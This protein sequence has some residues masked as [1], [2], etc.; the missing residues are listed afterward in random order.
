MSVRE[1]LELDISEAL[2]A[3]EDVGSRLEN[4]AQ[5][6]GDLLGEAL[7]GAL[8]GLPVITPEVD[9]TTVSE[10]V[11]GALN[12]ATDAP[13]EIDGEA[14]GVTDAVDSALADAETT[15]T[16]DADADAVTDEGQAAIDSID[17]TVTVNAD[18][19]QAEQAI[20]GLSD[21]LG[22]LGG[23]SEDAAGGLSGVT[24]AAVLAGRGAAGASGAVGRVTGAL[25]SLGPAGIAAGAAI[26]GVAAGAGFLYN[27]AFEAVAVTQAWENSL[28]DLGEQIMDLDGGATG[29]SGTIAQLAQDTGSSDE[30]VLIA[31]Q[32]YA[33]FQRAAGF[34]NDQIVEN[35]QGIVAL[36]AQIRVNNPNLGT[37]DQIITSLSRSLQRGGPRLQQF[38][39]ALNTADIEA[40][41][42]SMTGKTVATELTNAEKSAAGLAIAMEQIQPSAEGLAAGM[43]N[44]AIQSARAQQKIGDTL[45]ELGKPIVAPATQA[46]LA[47]AQAFEA[48]ASV[49]APLYQAIGKDLADA[50]DTASVSLD[51]W[52]WALNQLGSLIGDASDDVDDASSAMDIFGGV[53]EGVS[54][55]TINQLGPLGSLFNLLNDVRGATDDSGEAIATATGVYYG[56]TGAV[57]EAGQAVPQLTAEMKAQQV[58]VEEATAAFGP[59][60][61]SIN[62]FVRT[63]SSAVPTITEAFRG[64]TAE[65]DATTISQ[66][67]NL[68]ILAT[69]IWTDN[70][71][72][73]YSE[74][75]TNIGAV[76][77]ELGPQQSALLLEQYAG[78]E[79]EL[80]KHLAEMAQ[81]Q[82]RAFAAINETAVISYLRL[83]GITGDEARRVVQVLGAELQLGVPTQAAIEQVI[84]APT[85]RGPEVRKSFAT[86]SQDAANALRKNINA[87]EGAGIGANLINGLAFGL[88]S[89]QE[90]ALR[91]A[92]EVSN[93]IV[94]T[95]KG[96]FRVTSPSKVMADIGRDVTAG[97]ALGIEDGS[98]LAES[99]MAGL[100]NSMLGVSLSAGSP[101]VRD[102]SVTVPV[103]VSGGMSA[104]QGRQIGGEA[105]RAAALELSRM[106][107]TE[108]RLL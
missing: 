1:T 82:Q 15:V 95:V 70:M 100:S 47:L 84:A 57:D 90:A 54:R 68:Q 45:E 101:T 66:N 14:G 89:Q 107:R 49:V 88:I 46:F 59:A 98:S 16:L 97:L 102:V 67:L 56:Y 39:I 28:G 71:E 104:E 6:F 41:A 77:A 65:T 80:E 81:A 38:G 69:S 86:L 103:T 108:A 24:T 9:A 42:L 4:V 53:I 51:A 44:V 63:A 87:P 83:R 64:I 76:V 12:E 58:A 79:V 35:T 23:S 60:Y 22:S 13:L 73:L 17:G 85:Q 96:L 19:S 34:A 20:E 31:T 37:M 30:A 18:T 43:D 61:E 40:R 21:S 62:T 93:T 27:A 105:G 11:E 7:E 94:N 78:R 29:L 2:S 36:A 52:L 50:I 75:Y 106:L 25:S 91:A 92:R 33:E 26:G 55:A 8:S 99:A 3:I 32:R 48:V 74:G 5:A 10:E 72:R